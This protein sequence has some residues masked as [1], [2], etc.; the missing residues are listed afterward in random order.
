MH[1][2]LSWIWAAFLWTAFV[3]VSLY[4]RPLL[5]I[6]ETRYVSV[7]WEMWIHNEFLVPHLNGAVYSQKPP[8][9]FWLMHAGWWL[10]GVN[11]WWPR[12]IAPAFAFANLFLVSWFS[13]KLWPEHCD[14]GPR[15]SVIL[16]GFL[17]WS[18]F[19]TVTMFDMILAFFT[20]AAVSSVFL[21]WRNKPVGWWIVAGI[22]MG[23]GALTK[24]PVILLHVL[25]VA[26]LAPWWAERPPA[27]GWRNWYLFMIGSVLIGAGIALCWAVQAAVSGGPEYARAI[28]WT[29]TAGR[30]GNSF[31]HKQPW[32]FYG[33]LSPLWL[34]P[35]GIWGVLWKDVRLLKQD[36]GL[37]FCASWCIPV[38]VLLS[39][40]SG[41][42]L[43]YLLPLFP[44]FSLVV[45]RVLQNMSGPVPRKEQWGIAGVI[46]FV[47]AV[48][49]LAPLTVHLTGAP[50]WIGN[51]SPIWGMF[52]IGLAFMF[53]IRKP[54]DI[55]SAVRLLSF[56]SISLILII[57][58]S[59]FGGALP[60][61]DI[62]KISSHISGLQTRGIKI[63]QYGKYHGQY[64]FLGR[65][66]EPI[67]ILTD[68]DRVKVWAHNNPG[69]YVIMYCR[70][71]VSAD[72]PGVDYEQ[73]FRG[74]QVVIWKAAVLAER[75][76]LL[77]S[78]Y[79]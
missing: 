21:A 33:V 49:T 70:N 1:R 37:R 60:G 47:G 17:L 71:R 61:Y 7:A 28:F 53:F 20:L 57:N 48:L 55:T 41:K 14:K 39:L 56:T 63:S 26:L 34:Y 52:T 9:F 12:I 8:L 11:A 30:V 46:A 77:E 75:P 13:L 6:D 69:G 31:A 38:F 54:K 59:L 73:D 79:H 5:P 62:Q 76:K 51:I 27:G 10:F 36:R 4:C 64:H 2:Y 35:W 66:R 24:G 65:L 43:Y 68:L 58:F 44:A 40:I 78:M 74:K 32:W 19:A 15:S 22:A 29:Q 50:E 42:Q 45:C 16:A 23:L 3:I 67:E 18:L 25:P 72:E